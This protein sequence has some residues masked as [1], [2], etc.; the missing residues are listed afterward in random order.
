MAREA[1]VVP[2]KVGNYA[3]YDSFELRVF[4]FDPPIGQSD[5]AGISCGRP[6]LRTGPRK[7]RA[8]AGAPY[9]PVVSRWAWGASLVFGIRAGR[10][11]ASGLT[12]C[13]L[14]VLPARNGQD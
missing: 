12:R 3:K 7:Q 13:R 6:A 2:M 4:M 9:D 14:L 5:V 10:P 8:H 1:A 11:G